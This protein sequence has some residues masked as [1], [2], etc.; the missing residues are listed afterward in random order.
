MMLGVG[1]RWEEGG[2]SGFS[3]VGITTLVSSP[4]WEAPPSA[5]SAE[6]GWAPG[7]F[8]WGIGQ[9]G[10]K[11]PQ[12]RVPVWK[13]EE[14]SNWRVQVLGTTPLASGIASSP[15]GSTPSLVAL[16]ILISP[17]PSSSSTP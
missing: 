4:F 10:Q 16:P 9:G 14:K 6:G 8:S 15:Y 12:V 5:P 2:T 1:N 13:E 7:P 3:R 17:A 11:P